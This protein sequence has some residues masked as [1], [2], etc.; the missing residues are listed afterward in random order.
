MSFV[1]RFV[2]L[3]DGNGRPLLLEL[4]ERTCDYVQQSKM[5][6]AEILDAQILDTMNRVQSKEFELKI[7]QE[8]AKARAARAARRKNVDSKDDAKEVTRGDQALTHP[9]PWECGAGV[10][11]LALCSWLSG[12]Q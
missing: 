2:Q 5:I 11:A 6:K 4:V 12:H 9:R 3:E 7:K 8:Q 1:L 10:L